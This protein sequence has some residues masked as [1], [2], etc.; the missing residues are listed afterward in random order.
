LL[1]I[2]AT[3]VPTESRLGHDAVTGHHNREGILGVGIADG[4]VPIRYTDL[5][6]N[7]LVRDNGPE[8]DCHESQP[9]IDL[10]VG[11]GHVEVELELT[12]PTREVLL[13]LFRRTLDKRGDGRDSAANSFVGKVD[14]GETVTVSLDRPRAADTTD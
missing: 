3:G 9:H 6:R 8:G 12:P 1:D 2:K 13:E 11:S 5:A 10:E 7:V 4:A 14:L